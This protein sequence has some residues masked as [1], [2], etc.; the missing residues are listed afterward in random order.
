[1]MPGSACSSCVEAWNNSDYREAYLDAER[2]L[3]PLRIL[4]RAQWEQATRGLDSAVASPYAVS[5]FTLPRHWRFLDDLR[6]TMPGANVLPEGD[7]EKDAAGR[8]AASWLPQQTTLDDV[9]LK[10]QPETKN[11]KHGRQALALDIMPQDPKAIPLAL[12]RTFLALN[13]PAVRLQ[14]GTLVRISAWMAVPFPI[15]GSVDGALFYDSIGGEPLAI[16]VSSTP[17]GTWKQ[18]TLYRRVPASGTVSVTLALTG[19][20]RV[21][22]DDVRI[23]PMLPNSTVLSKPLTQGPR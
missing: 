22:F 5:F 13:S 16:R 4:M 1:M 15:T 10:I 17:G 19:L 9:T 12:D 21:L 7:F 14:P 8:I 18:F 11:P 2:A 20:G 6:Q 3:R 23:E